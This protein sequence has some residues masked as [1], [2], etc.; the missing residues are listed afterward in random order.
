MSLARVRVLYFSPA[1]GG[2]A[3][4]GGIAKFAAVPAVCKSGAG[5][6]QCTIAEWLDSRLAQGRGH[7][8]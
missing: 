3:G 7:L 1:K 4:E 2:Y 8:R 5:P 6:P